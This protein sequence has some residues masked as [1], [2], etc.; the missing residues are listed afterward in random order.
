LETSAIPLPVSIGP[1]AQAGLSAPGT[2][3]ATV[4]QETA[5]IL[6]GICVVQLIRPGT[7]VCFG[8]ICHAFDMR[9][10]QIIFGG[11][12][13]ALMAAACAQIGNYYGLPVY[14]NTGLTDSK[15]V[16]AQAGIEISATLLMAALAGSV[17][18]G[19]LGIAGADQGASLEMLFLQHEVIE[20]VERIMKGFSINDEKLALDV[21][22][23]V[24]HNGTFIDHVHTAMNFREELWM[25]KTLNRSSWS[26][27]QNDGCP[28]L[29]SII[30][31]KINEL[32]QTY[33]PEPLPGDLGREIDSLVSQA[34]K[35]LTE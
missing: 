10:M 28:N 24:G 27:W 1:M 8:G 21:I 4:T 9:T 17:I 29:A 12:E 5:E 19:H 16:D 25:P 35:K 31:P 15:C 30:E 20:Y 32:V 7:P 23:E 3:A 6:A 11:P 13:Q 18:F 33:K 26:E 34:Q 22:D 14:T 2:L